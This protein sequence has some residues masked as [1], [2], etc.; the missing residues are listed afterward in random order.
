MRQE[1]K[2]LAIVASLVLLFMSFECNVASRPFGG[3]FEKVWINTENLLLS[4]LPRGPVTPPGNGCTNTGNG[5]NP[6]IG[7]RK[8]AG[9]VGG[10]AAP[11]QLLA[12]RTNSLKFICDLI[13]SQ[14]VAE[15]SCLKVFS[16]DEDNF[17]RQCNLYEPDFHIPNLHR[18]SDIH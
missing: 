10:V 9:R 2:S 1:T 6:C 7:S 8:F 3:E 5:G 17:L 13:S 11:T 12:T 18:K 14:E 4:S 16:D 15:R